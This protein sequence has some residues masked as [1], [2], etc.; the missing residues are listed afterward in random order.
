MTQVTKGNVFEDLGFDASESADLALRAYLMAE[1]RKFIEKNKLTQVKAA[2]LFGITQ[3]K[4]SYI[5][6]G[7]VERISSDYLVGLLAKT[8]GEFRYSFKQPTKRQV[9]DRFST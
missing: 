3:P 5:M 1:L 2:K 8:G 6:N 7:M 9:A 4:I